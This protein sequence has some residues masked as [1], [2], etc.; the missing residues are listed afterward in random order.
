MVKQTH[1]LVA[2]IFGEPFNYSLYDPLIIQQRKP[3][4]SVIITQNIVLDTGIESLPN[5]SI[6]NTLKQFSF[7][8]AQKQK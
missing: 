2:S 4:V 1:Q 3:D 6:I 5:T 8:C 7:V